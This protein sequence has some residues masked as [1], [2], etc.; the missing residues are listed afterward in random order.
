MHDPIVVGVDGTGRSLKALVWAARDARLRGCPLRVVHTLP[1]YEMDIPL[2]PP[3]RFEVAEERGREIIAEALSI[4]HETHPD[5]EVSIAQPMSTPAAA[6]L[7]E[8][9]DAATVVLG[10]K[11]ENVGN[12]LLGSTVLQVVGHATCPVAVVPHVTTGHDRIAVGTDGSKDS[13]AALAYAFE[14]AK[15]RDA[16]I[17]VIS[18]LGL[19]QGWPTHLLRPLPP[20]DEEVRGRR[21]DVA[22]Q[23][24]P[25]RE[26]FPEIEVDLA[27][28]RLEPLSMLDDASHRADLIVLGSRGRGG[29]HGLALG[30]V[31]HKM[32]HLTGCPITVVRS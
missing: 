4:V 1:R 14:E 11:G 8:A 28:H 24:A 31:T 22:S 5:V 16:R 21:Q 26:R 19:P 20:D 17:E 3:G 2:F 23:V 29:F 18:A 13:T 15:M 25:F 10:A 6:L 30:S 9:E 7:A 32:L 27:V 12:L